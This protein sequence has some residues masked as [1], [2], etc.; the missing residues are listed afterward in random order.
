LLGDYTVA[1]NVFSPGNAPLP[2]LHKALHLTLF[3]SRCSRTVENLLENTAILNSVKWKL[4][5]LKGIIDFY[6]FKVEILVTA[7]PQ[8]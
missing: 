2:P 4:Q 6:I 1:N 3:I 5:L 8:L 7:E